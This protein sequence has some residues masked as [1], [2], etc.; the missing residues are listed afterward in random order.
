MIYKLI[1]FCISRSALHHLSRLLIILIIIIFQFHIHKFLLFHFV[2]VYHSF[3]MYVQKCISYVQQYLH[4][5]HFQHHSMTCHPSLLSTSPS[6]SFASSAASPYLHQHPISVLCMSILSFCWPYTLSIRRESSDKA[7]KSS[8]YK[9][10]FI[11][12]QNIHRDLYIQ[13]FSFAL[14]ILENTFL[15]P[16]TI[17]PSVTQFKSSFSHFLLTAFGKS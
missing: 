11:T 13:F 4:L 2:V 6:A 1:K 17:Q 16:Q 15:K 8:S 14:T 10:K 3:V 9:I 7:E 12:I 5:L